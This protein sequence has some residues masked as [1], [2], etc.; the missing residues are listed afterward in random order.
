MISV[1]YG[2][3][4]A[5]LRKN[6]FSNLS[7]NIFRSHPCWLV[8]ADFN[9]VTSMDEVSNLECHNT[10][11]SADLRDWIF[12]EGLIDLD[13]E[14]SKFTWMRGVNTESFKAARLDRAL[15]NVEWRLRY[16]NATIKHLP[17]INFDHTALLISNCPSL[18]GEGVRRFRFNMAWATS[19]EFLRCVQLSWKQNKNLE[20]NKAAVAEALTFW[21]RDYCLS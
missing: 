9:S 18:V 14:G 2:S 16:P 3:P 13:F 8:C 5:T 6:L 1:V 7:S 20:V 17:M 15:C 19:K 21:N 11:R 12:R 4:N 10:T